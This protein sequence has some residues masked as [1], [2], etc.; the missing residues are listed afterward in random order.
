MS[1]SASRPHW[2]PAG[3]PGSF[4][5]SS[6]W[7]CCLLHGLAHGS[8]LASR[9]SSHCSCWGGSRP[10]KLPESTEICCAICPGYKSGVAK[11]LPSLP[12]PLGVVGAGGHSTVRDVLATASFRS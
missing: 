12:L 3:S 2:L 7:H 9:F 5:H 4:P 1:S 6:S 8:S 10:G 11:L